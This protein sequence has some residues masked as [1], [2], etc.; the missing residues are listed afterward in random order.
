MRERGGR[1]GVRP[2]NNVPLCGDMSG[3]KAKSVSCRKHTWEW[4]RKCPHCERGH[5]PP[6][7]Q[8]G[9]RHILFCNQGFVFCSLESRCTE[10]GEFPIPTH[11]KKSEERGHPSTRQAPVCVCARAR[12]HVCWWIWLGCFPNC[13]NR[14][15]EGH[16]FYTEG[17]LK[18]QITFFLSSH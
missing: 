2:R 6:W 14:F 13:K 5:F 7:N 16:L 3:K 12:A 10:I 17:K 4:K 8:R 15:K 18:F 11:P 1:L 9:I